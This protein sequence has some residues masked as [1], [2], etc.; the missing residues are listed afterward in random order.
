MIRLALIAAIGLGA[1]FAGGH[2]L[3]TRYALEDRV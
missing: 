3:E 1:I 2:A